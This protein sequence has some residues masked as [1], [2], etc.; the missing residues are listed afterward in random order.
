[1]FFTGDFP[2]RRHRVTR[3]LA[4]YVMAQVEQPANLDRWPYPEGRLITLIL[5][6]CGLR[7][8]TA[9]TLAFDCLL[10]DGQ[11][12]PYLRYYNNKMEREAAVP[13]DEELEAEIRAQQRRVLDRWPEGNPNLFPRARTNID[14]R[15][16][17]SPDTYRAWMQRWLETCDVRD[18]HGQPVH[19]TPHQWRHTFA[20][21]LIN[22]DVPQ[23]VIRVL[24]DHESTQM[25]SH[26]AKIT[27][28]T[29]RRHW[30]ASHQGQHQGRARHPRPGRAAGPGSMGQD[31]LRHRHPDPAQRL[32]RAAA[33]KILP[34]RQRLPDLPG[35]PDRTRVPARATRT[36]PPHADPHR[37]L[38]GKGQTRMVEM[39]Q[40]V[41][42]QPRPHDR[43]DREGR[44]ERRR[45]CG[46]TTPATSSL[47]PVA[48]RRP[49]ANAPSP[50][51]DAWTRPGM[52]ITFDAVAREAQVSRSWLYNQPDLRAEV[53]R[54]RARRQPIVAGT[55]GS[56]QATRLG[57]LPAAAA[58]RRGRAHPA[59]G[60]RQ[61]AAPRGARPGPRRAP[62]G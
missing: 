19:L 7:V 53:E 9:S 35:F 51:C 12:A 25:T 39:N 8:S 4:E 44:A 40:Q 34:A 58:G 60:S 14:G 55:A 31:P 10:H 17:L 18:E 21:R 37:R 11:G 56:R 54:L 59:P 46:L 33:A 28:Q 32:L 36:A 61:P 38:R 13:I 49:P 1:M 30:E 42:D 45:R 47:P 62:R 48:G 23:E 16:P 5:I 24:L 3:H 50:P 57:R 22:R 20:T 43:R 29:V 27:D 52:P 2:R 26:Y 6:R 41:L 15:R